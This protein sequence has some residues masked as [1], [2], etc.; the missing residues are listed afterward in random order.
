[1]QREIYNEFMGPYMLARYRARRQAAIEYLGGQCNKRGCG[2]MTRLHFDHIDPLTKDFVIGKMW[3]RS[4]SRFWEEVRKCQ[5]L[6]LRHHHEK[7]LKDMGR[8]SAK[9]THGT[10]SSYR[11]CKCAKCKRAKSDWQREYMVKRRQKTDACQSGT[12]P[13]F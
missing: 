12:G 10:L 3:S 2:E 7:T 13:V 5:L 6:C 1:M 4:L 11:Y 9:K 8:V